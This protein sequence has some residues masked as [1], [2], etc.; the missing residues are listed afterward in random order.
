MIAE[1]VYYTSNMKLAYWSISKYGK[2]KK[3]YVKNGARTGKGF[4]QEDATRN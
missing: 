1:E 4:S 2:I 3:N